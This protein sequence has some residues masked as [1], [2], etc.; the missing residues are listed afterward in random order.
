MALALF[1]LAL[2]VVVVIDPFTDPQ[3]GHGPVRYCYTVDADQP[4]S[5]Y[6]KADR[7]TGPIPVWVGPESEVNAAYADR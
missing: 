4:W 3:I 5:C 2:A 7:P 1:T 6:L